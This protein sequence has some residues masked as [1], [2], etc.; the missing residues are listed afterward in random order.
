MLRVGKTMR[1]GKT[2]RVV[3]MVREMKMVRVVKMVRVRNC[4]RSERSSNRWRKGL[5]HNSPW[6]KQPLTWR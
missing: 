1:V 4:Q 3:K 2:V 5:G 6:D